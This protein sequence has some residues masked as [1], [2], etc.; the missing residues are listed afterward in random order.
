MAYWCAE[1]ECSFVRD[2]DLAG[3]GEVE[4]DEDEEECDVHY[5]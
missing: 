4:G 5:E 3:V 1:V 2:L